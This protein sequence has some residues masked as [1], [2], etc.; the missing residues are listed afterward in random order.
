MVNANAED[1]YFTR[2]LPAR[3]RG[4]LSK[5]HDAKLSSPEPTHSLIFPLRSFLHPSILQPFGF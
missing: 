5:Q 3:Y 4:E 2:M 1:R